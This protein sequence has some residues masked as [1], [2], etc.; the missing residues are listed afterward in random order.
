MDGIWQ[1]FFWD[2][3]LLWYLLLGFFFGFSIAMLVYRRVFV[4]FWGV[5]GWRPTVRFL[6]GWRK[7]EGL[8]LQRA[9]P[10]MTDPWDWYIF[11]YTPVI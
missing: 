9:L 10:C 7:G 6:N 5:D 4:F 3:P 11:T 2:S 8:S 1:D